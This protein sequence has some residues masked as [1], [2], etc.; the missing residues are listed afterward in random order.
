[1]SARIDDERCVSCGACVYQCPFGAITDR[2]SIVQII[3]EIK[4]PD[5]HVYAIIAPS[6]ASQFDYATTG[7]VVR[8]AISSTVMKRIWKNRSKDSYPSTVI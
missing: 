7:Q 1:M 3:E 6:F 8:D 5:N 2:S 4:K